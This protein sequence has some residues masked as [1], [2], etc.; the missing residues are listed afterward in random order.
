MD[1]IEARWMATIGRE[2]FTADDRSLWEQHLNTCP[3]CRTLVA[4]DEAFVASLRH[5]GQ[6]VPLDSTRK[7]TLRAELM[8][9]RRWRYWQGV[10]RVASCAGAAAVVLLLI[11]GG[12]HHQRPAPDAADLA[13][14]QQRIYEAPRDV[15]H[16]WWQAQGLIPPAQDWNFDHYVDHGW[17]EISGVRAPQVTFVR[18]SAGGQRVDTAKLIALRPQDFHLKQLTDAQAS[19]VFITV[20]PP[21]A[22]QRW[23]WLVIHTTP[24]I[25][26]F[27]RPQAGALATVF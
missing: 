17:T 22:D 10:V 24:T 15:V 11:Y 25:E 23:V 4:G 8:Q 21:V 12:I 3:A 16:S 2:G 18:H 13:L 1:C 19:I 27:L 6:Q 26:P 5:V 9:R 14:N 20:L 7:A